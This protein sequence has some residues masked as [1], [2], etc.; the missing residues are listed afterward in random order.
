M[1]AG[2]QLAL[3]IPVLIAHIHHIT[4][5][6]LLI[7]LLWR[8]V[9]TITCSEERDHTV[10]GA[11]V[12]AAALSSALLAM[13][14]QAGFAGAA[15]TPSVGS[16]FTGVV[17]QVAKPLTIGGTKYSTAFA[18]DEALIYAIPGAYVVLDNPNYDWTV[19]A[20]EQWLAAG[21]NQR[22][23]D[24]FLKSPLASSPAAQVVNKSS[25]FSRVSHAEQLV[26]ARS[27]LFASGLFGYDNVQ[28]ITNA[29]VTPASTAPYC[30][31]VFDQ[32]SDFLL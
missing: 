28:A 17:Y 6:T 9:W 11:R 21:G 24:D 4:F 26:T 1:A 22:A 29:P 25:L 14:L 30:N 20:K 31:A 10:K 16:M 8:L 15:S 3:I 32:G 19:S 2:R 23:L 13:L 5:L 18:V 12:V 27:R 7:F